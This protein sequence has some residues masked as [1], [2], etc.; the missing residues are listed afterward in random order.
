MKIDAARFLKDLHDLRAIGAAGV[1]KGVVRPA[2][3][4]ADVEAREWLAGRMRDAGLKVEVDAMGNLFGL[5]DGPSILLGSHSDSQPEGG[6][7]DGALGVIAALEVARAAGEAGGPAVSV[8]SFQDEEGRFGVTTG[9]TVWSGAL[10]QAEADGFTDDAGV[11][12]AEARRAM[13]GMV[14]GPVDPAQFTGYIELHIEQG[15]TLDDSGEQIG[16][17]SDIV[18]IRDMKVTFEGQQNHAGTT[19][20]AVRRDAFQAVSEF[21]SLLNDRLRNVVTPS[22]VWTIGHVSLHPNAS[23]IVPGKAVFSMQ[24]RDGDSDRLGRMEKIIRETAEEVAK[25]R[26]MDLSFG[27]ILG[28]E[29]V[30]MDA[31]LRDALAEAAEAV[32]PGKWRKM[33]SGALHDATNVAR[34]MPVAMLFAPSIN[35]IS[36]AFEEDTDEADLV[37]A[38]EVLGRA[39]AAL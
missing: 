15:P 6:W 10:D 39:V 8:V 30:S 24:W 20:M 29:P 7:L 16:V 26:G 28:L 35:G 23:S 12:L 3:S 2:Y 14:T 11:S 1:G 33:P 17:V 37:A 4:A 25:G 18:G 13:A 21:N 5:A 19:P 36:H 38:V 27:P 32:A 22:T 9:S 31:Q 34:L